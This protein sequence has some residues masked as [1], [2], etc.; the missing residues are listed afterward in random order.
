MKKQAGRAAEKP[1]RPARKPVRKGSVPDASSEAIA[2]TLSA[3]DHAAVSA[4]WRELFRTSL[5]DRQLVPKGL[6]LTFSTGDEEALE[7]LVDIERAC[8][9]WITF[10]LD[11]P[12]VTL[13]AEGV[14]EQAIQALWAPET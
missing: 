2:C 13:T 9:R 11:G 5:A 12:T 10:V 6:Q 4:A 3:S 7:R 14:G 8:C 1:V